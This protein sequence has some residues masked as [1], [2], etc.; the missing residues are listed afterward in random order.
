MNSFLIKA[1]QEIVIDYLIGSTSFWMWRNEA[2]LQCIKEIKRPEDDYWSYYHRCGVQDFELFAWGVT[3]LSLEHDYVDHCWNSRSNP[4][5]VEL[6][7]YFFDYGC[8][9]AK[10]T[11][12]SQIINQY[13]GF[14]TPFYSNVSQT[15]IRNDQLLLLKKNKIWKKKEMTLFLSCSSSR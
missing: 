12:I 2:C 10:G 11:R 8:E 3:D 9:Y 4:L 5:Y 1:W 7:T 15:G 14:L 13:V 6:E